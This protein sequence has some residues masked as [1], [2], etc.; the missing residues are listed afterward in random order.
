MFLISIAT[1]S[2]QRVTG[3]GHI[4]TSERSVEPFKSIQVSHGW[5]LIL[6]QG[7]GHHMVIEADENVMDLLRTEVRN[8]VLRIYFDDGVQIRKSGKKLIHLTFEELKSIEASGGS[9]VRSEDVLR[10]GDLK[11][12]LSGG[13]DLEMNDLYAEEL[14]M[15]LSGGSDT[16]IDF[17]ACQ[18]LT[19]QASGGSDMNLSDLDME[20]CDLQ[21]SGGSDARLQGKVVH[22]K[23]IAS[24]GS[25]ISA[26]D[27][28]IQNCKL[29]LGG[30]SDAVLHCEQEID[31]TLGGSSDLSYTGRPRVINT[32]VCRSCSIR[33][34]G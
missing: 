1:S 3:S 30:G 15:Q 33:A 10:T 17:G 16:K 26:R 32:T 5:D 13:S 22:A 18:E 24:G 6:H 31:I 23:I 19:V 25:D 27:L 7:N 4:V 12:S 9:D 29:D 2:G 20:Y 34:R 8:G 11:L 28:E 14:S 21:L